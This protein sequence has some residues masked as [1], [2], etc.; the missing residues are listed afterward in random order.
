MTQD[1]HPTSLPKQFQ[2][3]MQMASQ[4]RCW[5]FGVRSDAVWTTHGVKSGPE[6]PNLQGDLAAQI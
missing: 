4:T 6:F 5:M 3:A 1:R 2:V